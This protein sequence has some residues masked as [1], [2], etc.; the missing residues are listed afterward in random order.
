M[1]RQLAVFHDV[2]I[3]GDFERG[4]SKLLDE[5]HR[6]FFLLQP[7]DDREHLF[8]EAR[9]KPHRR[10]V[11][12]QHL[13]LKHQRARHR[14]HLLFAARQRAGQLIA[15]LAQPR[16]QIIHPVDIALHVALGA[17]TGQPCKRA[18]HEVVRHRQ[19]WKHAAAFRRMRDAVF[20]D[21]VRGHPGNVLA[22]KHHAAAL[23]LD[24]PG[25]RPQRGGLASPVRTDQRDE[26]PLRNLHRNALQHLNFAVSGNQIFNL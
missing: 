7:P 22:A 24:H 6:D 17:R 18:E 14:Q 13:R 5:Q 3:V 16:K 1:H 9:R 20:H 10:L 25:Q 12:Q 19:R 8:D 23:G 21:F 15:P 26:L 4:G 11:Q 2:A